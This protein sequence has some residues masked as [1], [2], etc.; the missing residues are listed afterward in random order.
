[1]NQYVLHDPIRWLQEKKP[2]GRIKSLAGPN[3]YFVVVVIR[4]YVNVMG[5]GAMGAISFEKAFNYCSIIFRSLRFIHVPHCRCRL[6]CFYLAL[7]H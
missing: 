3:D 1:M 6:I 5:P 4:G 7:I 2:D